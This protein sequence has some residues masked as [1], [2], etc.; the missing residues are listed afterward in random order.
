MPLL[1]FTLVKTQKQRHPQHSSHSSSDLQNLTGFVFNIN[2]LAIYRNSFASNVCQHFILKSR[3]FVNFS[4]PLMTWNPGK[5]RKVF[6][7]RHSKTRSECDRMEI[8]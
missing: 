2:L 8:R 1:W 3:I 5:S 7:R 4:N 6:S